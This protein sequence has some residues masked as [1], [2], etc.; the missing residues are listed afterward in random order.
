MSRV[1]RR[2][3]L[4]AAKKQRGQQRHRR[5]A[6]TMDG[7]SVGGATIPQPL[8]GIL[9]AVRNPKDASSTGEAKTRRLRKNGVLLYRLVRR[10]GD[11]SQSRQAPG[12]STRRTLSKG[13]SSS[14]AAGGATCCKD[15][16]LDSEIVAESRRL[17]VS[18]RSRARRATASCAPRPASP[19]EG[20]VSVKCLAPICHRSVFISGGAPLM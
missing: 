14:S 17:H 3:R 20:W 8:T 18:R 16:E 19:V 13:R 5:H 4:R 6:R 9:A 11:R 10:T 1:L 15:L 2:H 7:L 12:G